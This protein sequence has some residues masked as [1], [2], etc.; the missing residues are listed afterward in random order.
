MENKK[1]ALYARVSTLT[2]SSGLDAQLNSLQK[3]CR[4]NSIK[5]YQIFS[6]EGISGAKA[7]RP[8]LDILM[9]EARRGKIRKL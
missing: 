9:A 1:S 6:D 2:Q 7:N 3:Y 5:K 4:H 8:E